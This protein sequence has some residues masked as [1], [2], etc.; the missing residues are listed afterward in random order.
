M[1]SR[2]FDKVQRLVKWGLPF[3]LFTFLP[4][5]LLSQTLTG[6]AP[7]HVSVGEQFRLTYTVNTQNATDFRAGDIPGELEVLI[8]PNR[9][10]QS[11]YQM[12]NGYTSSS[13]SITYTYIVCATKNGTFI[14]PPAHVVVGGKT[15]ASNTLN[16]KVSG[17]PQASS[18][19]SG[20]PRQHR[21]DE[22]GEIRDAGSQISGSDLFIK[23]SA[24]KKRVYEQEP[25][26]LT[27]KVYTLVGLTSLRGDMPD[28][29][30]FY[31]QEVSL[32]TQ[33]SFSIET[34]NGRPYRTTTWSQYVMFP[35]MTGKLQIPSIT[36]E[37]I[38]VQQN[39][40]IDPFE[41][42]FN[43]GSGYIEVKKKIVAPGIDIEVDPLPERPAGFSGGVGHF[44]VSAS[45]N[46]T[47]T[48]ANDPVSVRI[49]VSG[50]GNLKLVKQPQ[51]ELPKDFD[52]YEPKVTDK[53][54]LTTAGIEG[55]MIYD[56]LIVPRHQGHY[57]IPPVSLT[58]FDTTSK[59]YKT[60][61]SEPL[62]LDV[63]KGSGPS[64][65]SD[66]SG[67]QD[68][69]ELSRDIRYIKTGNV[70]QQGIDEFFFGSVPYWITLA[71]MVLVFISLFV[72]FRQRAI[73]NANVTKRR[74]GK[75]NK[76][77]T[78]RLKKASK[79]M[80]DNKPGEFYDEV[81][82]ALWGYVGDKLNIPVEQL[83]H[84]NISQRLSDRGVGEETIAQFM[85]A[86]DECE[87]ERYA[88]GDPKGNM[89]KVYEKAMTAIEQIEGT[90]KK[91]GVRS[92]ESSRNAR[93]LLLV[94]YLLLTPSLLTPASAVTKAEADSSYV[95]GQYQQAI[96]QYEALL[97]QGASADLYYN[98]GNA[99]YRTENIPEAV[100]NYERA[101]LLSPGDRDIRFNL[102]IARSKTFDKIVP[103]SEM[104][105]V[106]WY[107]SLVSMMSVDAWARTALVSLAITIILLLVYLFSERIW[108]RKAGFFGGVALLLLF[109][110]ANIFAWQQKKDL[111]N[112]KGAIIFAPS[113]T[114]KSTPA[115]NGTDLFILHEGTKVVIT[116]GSMKEW[117]EIRLADGKEGWIESKHI[118][119]I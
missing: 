86:L 42:F 29:K 119:V 27:Y 10:M 25:I 78:K 91:K 14:I 20:S 35:Q 68:L 98:L 45:L 115:A 4:L 70:R 73:E 71:I 80:A 41:A 111:L 57:D 79:L 22:Q 51:I 62:T 94:F 23:V 104:F 55:S 81:L 44:T 117:K 106:T 61:T 75:A 37:G 33:K 72:I 92:Q 8:G 87:F 66:Y 107:R 7:S 52:K 38:V 26:L 31:T 47:E 112:R 43:G 39:R 17:S 108:L 105:F 97:K 116:D 48:K 76:V 19:S 113:V 90:M 40:N 65:M 13:S 3:Y 56:I 12:I 5:S 24:N 50:T 118:R 101:L 102:Q 32:P 30:S 63:A 2:I 16:I 36:F 89:N 28:L 49:T 58:Y 53:T 100:L 11:S 18:G 114:V 99:Y 34:F 21:Q 109:V 60:V 6:S 95:R 110:G 69:Q 1:I 82:R 9:S 46:K 84:D 103:E 59:T 54:K 64:A 15:I 83:S 67:Q 96:T 85:G 88:P 93:V 77:A 74:A